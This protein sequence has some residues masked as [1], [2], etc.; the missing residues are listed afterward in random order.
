[1]PLQSSGTSSARC[2]SGGSLDRHHVQAIKQVLAKFSSS[3][4]AT[5]PDRALVV[6][7]TRTIHLLADAAANPLERAFLKHAKQLGLE[8]RGD[9]ADLVQQERAAVGKFEPAA[10]HFVCTSERAFFVA[11]QFRFGAGFPRCAAQC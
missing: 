9:L 2:R 4:T 3:L 10:A 1:M 7:I 5:L 11:E 8:A 6:A